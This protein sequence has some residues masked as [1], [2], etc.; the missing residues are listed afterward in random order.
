MKGCLLVNKSEMKKREIGLA[1][2]EQ[3]IGF[4]QVKQVINYHDW[5]CIFVEVESKIPLWQIVL[6]LE[7]KETTTAYG[8]GNTEN[9]A[10]QNAI[11]VLAKR[12]QD[13]VY[14]EC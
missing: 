10:R 1:D 3:E 13:K 4:E 2:F 12:I 6:N 11:E 9:E 14:L 8:F 7:W 5:L